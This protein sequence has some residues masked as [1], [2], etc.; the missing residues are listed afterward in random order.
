MAI[1]ASLGNTVYR[2]LCL[3]QK[4]EMYSCIL[5]TLLLNIPQTHMISFPLP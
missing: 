3:E 2:V 5:I 1:L 4:I